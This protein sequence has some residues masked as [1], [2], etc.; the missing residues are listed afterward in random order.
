MPDLNTL[1]LFAG[2]SALLIVMPGPAVIY[3][4]A[5]SVEHGRDAGLVSMF[6]VEVASLTHG[7]AAAIGVSA[8]L[9]SSATAFGVVKYAGAAYLIYLGVRALTDSGE[10]PEAAEEPKRTSVRSLFLWGYLVGLLNPKTALFFL[11]FLPQ[12]VD[13]AQG[14]VALQIIILSLVFTAIGVFSDGAYALV[15]GPRVTGCERS[16]AGGASPGPAAASTS[17]SA[18]RPRSLTGGPSATSPLG[19][20]AALPGARHRDVSSNP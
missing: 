4:V 6:G 16:G 12:F 19:L 17:G 10:R 8:L 13:P 14:A 3:I 11:A 9:A 2:A 15:G 5:R 1:T 7:L 18:S 20:R